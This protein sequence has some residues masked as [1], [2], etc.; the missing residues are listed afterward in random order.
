MIV[1]D[2]FTK[3]EFGYSAG[4][5]HCGN[6]SPELNK[7]VVID[8]CIFHEPTQRLLLTGYNNVV[9][10]RSCREELAKLLLESIKKENR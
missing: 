8:T 7:E 6:S 9:L 10:C 3:I 2:E 1:Q 5:D 4:C